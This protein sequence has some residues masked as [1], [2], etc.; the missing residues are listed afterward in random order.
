MSKKCTRMNGQKSLTKALDFA[1]RAKKPQQRARASCFCNSTLAFF[2]LNQDMP[3]DF[4][5]T[6]DRPQTF[7]CD[8]SG[9]NLILVGVRAVRD[10]ARKRTKQG[11]DK[12]FPDPFR[13]APDWQASCCNNSEVLDR[14]LLPQTFA[15]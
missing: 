13:T 9:K 4:L 3:N 6:A 1:S 15:N 5:T 14:S 8:F 11:A 7:A 2:L 10:G 12:I